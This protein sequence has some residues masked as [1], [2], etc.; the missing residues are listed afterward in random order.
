MKNAENQKKIQSW[1]QENSETVKAEFF[2]QD[3]I[4]KL[5]LAPRLS[6]WSNISLRNNR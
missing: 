6:F 1:D 5:Q 4:N 2:P 3:N